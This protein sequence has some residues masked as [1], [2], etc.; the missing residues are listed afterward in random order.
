MDG[1]RGA[2][3]V[4][5]EISGNLVYPWVL[6]VE[7]IS[8]RPHIYL[9]SALDVVFREETEAVQIDVILDS[10]EEVRESAWT[11][12]AAKEGISEYFSADLPQAVFAVIEETTEL[13]IEISTTLD[14]YVIRFNVA[15]LSGQIDSLSDICQ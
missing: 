12:F 2:V 11:F 9:Y 4:G 5:F 8:D 7:C 14:P 13:T 15:G 3:V 1:S 6:S 10:D